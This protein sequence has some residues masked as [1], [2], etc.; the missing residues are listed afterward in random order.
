MSEALARGQERLLQHVI[1]I[2][3]AAQRLRQAKL[4][5]PPETFALPGEQL[6]QSLG[7]AFSQSALKLAHPDAG[8][9]TH[10]DLP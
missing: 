6:G 7:I 10:L 1:R 9:A 3:S 4:N 8:I 2:Q 5:N